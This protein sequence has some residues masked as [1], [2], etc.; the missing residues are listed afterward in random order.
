[1]TIA[2]FIELI[3]QYGLQAAEKVAGS[4]EVT[5]GPVGSY[6]FYKTKNRLHIYLLPLPA[7]DDRESIETLINLLDIEWDDEYNIIGESIFDAEFT[8]KLI[9]ECLL[10][11]QGK[12]S[13]AALL[14]NFA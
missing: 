10:L 14:K 12:V 13:L 1:M 8:E 5:S 3:R 6:R 7:W 11:E 4:S 9:K 2:K